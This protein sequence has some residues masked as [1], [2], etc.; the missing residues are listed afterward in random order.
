VKDKFKLIQIQKHHKLVTFK[1]PESKM[2]SAA[3]S[4]QKHQKSE[5]TI[6]V[7]AK[8]NIRNVK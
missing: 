3:G 4:S 5:I 1:H 2:L 8:I 7:V 6:Y